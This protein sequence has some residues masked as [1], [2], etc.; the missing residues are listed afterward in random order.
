MDEIEVLY[1]G[2]GGMARNDAWVGGW[3]GGWVDE[4]YRRGALELGGWMGGLGGWVGW[5]VGGRGVPAGGVWSSYSTVV[6]CWKSSTGKFCSE[7]FSA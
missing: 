1:E 4:A 2:G 3:A 7:M 6:N 5:W